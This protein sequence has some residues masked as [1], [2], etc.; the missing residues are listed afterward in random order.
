MSVD[1]EIA[2]DI[3]ETSSM[4]AIHNVA[5][6]RSSI[7]VIRYKLKDEGYFMDYLDANGL[8]SEQLWE[9]ELL[10]TFSKKHPLSDRTPLNA[11][12]LFPHV[13]V[14][15]A[16]ET[17]PYIPAR[18]ENRADAREDKCI[19]V[20]NRMNVL[21]IL[22]QVHSAYF[23]GAP[24]PEQ[25]LSRYGLMQVPCAQEDSKCRDAV[26]YQKKHEFSTVEKHLINKL[27]E[28]RNMMTFRER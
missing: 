14:T 3:C 20:M 16:D 5:R 1:H 18:E 2:V 12:M 11:D 8:G 22:S 9:F 6:G 26:I 4:Q 25:M 27:F 10:A 13:E 7:G 23:W 28:A 19:S 15:L 21:E 17:V 24:V